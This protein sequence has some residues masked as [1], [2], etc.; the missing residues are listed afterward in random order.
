MT[1]IIDNVVEFKES[2]IV[3]LKFSTLYFHK[4]YIISIVNEGELI[5]RE[6]ALIVYNTINEHYKGSCFT[7]ISYRKNSYSVDPTLYNK[8]AYN[9][10]YK[11]IAI[12]SK[13]E[14]ALDSSLLEKMFVKN[15]FKTFT[16]IKEAIDW[17]A[18]LAKN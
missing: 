10:H 3:R 7:Y 13:N 18:D 16:N 15:M 1:Q 14:R 5:D 12:V 17:A 9:T 8:A 6:K 2:D 4:D 11:A